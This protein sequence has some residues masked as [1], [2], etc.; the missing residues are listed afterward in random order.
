[1]TTFCP[2]GCGANF[3]L[4]GSY[5]RQ[6]TPGV[7]WSYDKVYEGPRQPHMTL[8]EMAKV[9]EEFDAPMVE[10]VAKA[11]FEALDEEVEDMMGNDRK[12]SWRI[13]GSSFD[14]DPRELCEWQRDEYRI[15]AKA[16]IKAM[17]VYQRKQEKE[18][19]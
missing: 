15:Q 16:A 2:C 13:E 4:I 5:C 8:D 11:I 17:R 9:Q 1:M 7:G 6:Y 12:V 10:A 14:V 18:G 3:D 19:K